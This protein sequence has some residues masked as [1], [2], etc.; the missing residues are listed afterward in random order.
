[1]T[2]CVCEVDDDRINRGKEFGRVYYT[3]T[4]SEKIHL[5]NSI[6]DVM[7]FIHFRNIVHSEL[8]LGQFMLTDGKAACSQS[9]GGGKQRKCVLPTSS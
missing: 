8:H 7:A 1:M 6:I 5:M 9:S 4:L 3:M 2:I